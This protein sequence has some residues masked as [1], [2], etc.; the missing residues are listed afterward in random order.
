[1]GPKPAAS[2]CRPQH[3]TT[4]EFV[5][6]LR[7]LDIRISVDGE[8]LRCSAPK[9]V[10]TDGL[11]QELA[12]R[13]AELLAWLRT[14]ADGHDAVARAP[15]ADGYDAPLQ[16][17]AAYHMLGGLCAPGSG[18]PRMPRG[19]ALPLWFAQQRLWF[20]DQLE[21]GT[22]AYTIAVRRRFH[23]PLDVTA[24]A[25]ACTELVRRHEALR[26]TF[27]SQEGQPVQCIADPEPVTLGLIDLERH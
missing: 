24:L 9:G 16:P 6:H 3:I 23:G 2:L 10:L 22:P 8:R 11:R 26:T 1:M 20:P 21:P 12:A 27:V 14:N 4:A 15:A 18:P 19:G 25:S 7:T 17:G 13:K 5:A